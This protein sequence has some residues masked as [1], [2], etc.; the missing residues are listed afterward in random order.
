MVLANLNT[1]ISE[2]EK[3]TVPLEIWQWILFVLGTLVVLTVGAVVGS[4]AREYVEQAIVPTALVE[5]V[6]LTFLLAPMYRAAP[7]GLGWQWWLITGS[8]IIVLVL[9]AVAVN[10]LT[11]LE[12]SPAHLLAAPSAAVVIAAVYD[13]MSERL[14]SIPL[15]W[16]AFIIAGIILVAY[17]VGRR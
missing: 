3:F 8:L 4:Y 7:P 16:G 12:P 14:A 5:G 9:G 15:S 2:P 1:W 10:A 13:V 11:A 17:V 6:I